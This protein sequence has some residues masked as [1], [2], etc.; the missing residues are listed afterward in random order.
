M[1]CDDNEKLA[2]GAQLPE[3]RKKQGVVKKVHSVAADYNVKSVFESAISNVLESQL[4]A[5]FS[6]ARAVA[7]GECYAGGR[8][9]GQKMRAR[10][11]AHASCVKGSMP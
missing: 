10:V 6:G 7:V 9:A 3:Q 1:R 8:E 2:A 5:R 11:A 4:S